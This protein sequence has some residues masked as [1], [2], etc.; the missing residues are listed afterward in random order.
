MPPCGG[1]TG[2]IAILSYEAVVTIGGM[3]RG[4][5]NA[6]TLLLMLLCLTTVVLWAYSYY[7]GY[8][9][10]LQ[11]YQPDGAAYI[12]REY[13]LDSGC[14]GI[15]IWITT[16]W[17]TDPQNIAMYKLIA[18]N[19]TQRKFIHGEFLLRFPYADVN[20]KPSWARR[21]GFNGYE[22]LVVDQANGGRFSTS[23][24]PRMSVGTT[25]QRAISFPY[26]AAVCLLLTPIL[27]VWV[28]RFRRSVAGLCSVCGY[29]LRATPDRC[30]ECGAIPANI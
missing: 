6:I 10:Q 28:F 2:G 20:G 21:L 7:H 29:D 3:K 14:G 8:W 11:T 23:E 5:I 18:A 4:I 1:R 30:P 26:W 25:R 17:E 16:F 9:I 27:L 24:K 13:R 15:G 19:P 12:A 22:Y